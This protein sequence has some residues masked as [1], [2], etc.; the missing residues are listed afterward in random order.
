M[1]V[2]SKDKKKRH[3]MG[4]F[5]IK[6]YKN[7]HVTI[8]DS[9][10]KITLF[11]GSCGSVKN[12]QGQ[13]YKNTKKHKPQAAQILLQTA[14][15]VAKEMGMVF[16]KLEIDGDGSARDTAQMNYL[17]DSGIQFFEYCDKTRIAHAGCKKPK[18]PSK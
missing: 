13:Q 3:T 6:T 5:K 14:G 18:K 10:G 12:Q 2:S 4:I 16:A 8:T 1:S 17:F 7:T 9:T 15:Q 11:N